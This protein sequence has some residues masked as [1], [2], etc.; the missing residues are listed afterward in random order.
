M[1]RTRRRCLAELLLR[2]L[3]EKSFDA[4]SGMLLFNMNST[5]MLVYEAAQSGQWT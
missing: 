4:R 5:T 3:R 2:L 1:A